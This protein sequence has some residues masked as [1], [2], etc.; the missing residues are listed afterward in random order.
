ME[1]HG[2]WTRSFQFSECFIL[3]AILSRNGRGSKEKGS[4]HGWMPQPGM[5]EL[6]AGVAA[7]QGP[8]KSLDLAVA[9]VALW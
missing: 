4:S 5:D 9:R 1:F 6:I 3:N 7:L 8:A 2:I